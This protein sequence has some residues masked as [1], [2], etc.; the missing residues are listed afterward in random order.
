MKAFSIVAIIAIIL[1]AIFS[2]NGG[3]SKKQEIDFLRINNGAEPQSLDPHIATGVP[4]SHILEAL[5]EG[6]TTLKQS[7]L[8]PQPGMAT[9]W[10]VSEDLKTYTFKMRAGAKWSNG[11]PFTAN[12]F[13]NSW[14]RMLRLN[15]VSEYVSMLFVIEGAE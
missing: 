2:S 5:Y 10:S 9:S 4:E 11:D 3:D 8:S 15:P 7:D 12:D 13:V 14:H 1:I 6:L